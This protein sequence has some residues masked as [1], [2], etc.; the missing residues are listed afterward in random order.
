MSGLIAYR[1]ILLIFL[2]VFLFMQDVMTWTTFHF[3]ASCW[4]DKA[5]RTC[6]N[7]VGSFLPMIIMH[8]LVLFLT[9]KSL[10][11]GLLFVDWK[12]NYML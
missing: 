1:Y 8:K 11:Q 2:T 6:W 4:F 9:V 7:F 12:I 5:S 3:P 10:L